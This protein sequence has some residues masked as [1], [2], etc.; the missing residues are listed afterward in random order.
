MDL[1]EHQKKILK[2]DRKK[3]GIFLGTGGGKT[4][5]ALELAVGSTLVVCP[6]QQYL[7]KTWERNAEKFGIRINLTT[8]SKETF[9]RDWNILPRYETLIID[10]AHNNFGVSPET[11]QR[12]H[13]ESPKTSQIF[14]AT[15]NYI[16]KNKPDRFYPCTATP[17]SKPMNLWAIATLMGESWDFYKFRRK[18]YNEV[19]IGR[20]R[21]WMPKKNEEIRSRLAEV[22]QRLGYTGTL[23][24]FFDVPDQTHKTVYIELG[25]AQKLA[26][27]ELSKTEAD[28]LVKRSR[29]RTIE[30]GVLYGKKIETL[31]EKEDIMT[32]DVVIFPSKKID[33]ILERAQE[34]PKL[35]VFAN[36]KAQINEIAKALKHEGYNV[37]TLTGETKDRTFL[38]KVDKSSD[39]HIIVAQSGISSGYELPSFP[40]VI[41]ASKSWRYVDYEQSLGRVLRANA[42]KKNLYIHLIV[43][44]GVDDDCHKAI[45]AGQDFQTKM[46]SNG[47]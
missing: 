1:Y 11:K 43:K 26:L 46:M 4:R 12:K 14:E 35:L 29:A 31:N 42:L 30:N 47:E 37:S 41:Y 21:I 23:N 13:I 18:Y 44:G 15:F 20:R 40:C 24:D 3:T 34:F 22:I 39:P 27:K 9:R 32:D 17:I 19:A 45:M 38:E 16:Q 8:I 6:K 28:P 5:I 33:Y 2:E 7:D 10:E 36:Y 25:E